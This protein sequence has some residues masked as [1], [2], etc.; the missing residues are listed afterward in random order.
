MWPRRS[1]FKEHHEMPQSTRNGGRRVARILLFSL[2]A[3]ALVA[4]GRAPEKP[5]RQAIETEHEPVVPPTPV[6]VARARA[7][8]SPRRL[9]MSFAVAV[10]FFAGASFSAVAGDR[11]VSLLGEEGDAAQVAAP[12]IEPAVT[13]TTGDATEPAP[14]EPTPT[15]PAPTEPAP[16][17]AE[18]VPAEPVPAEPAPAEPAPAPEADPA[19]ATEDED[20]LASSWGREAQRVRARGGQTPAAPAVETETPSAPEAQTPSEDAA[21]AHVAP[22]SAPAVPSRARVRAQRIAPAP[23]AKPVVTAP[24]PRATPLDPE[25]TAAGVDATVWVN[26]QLPDPTPPSLRLSPA[27]AQNLVS[28]SR[29]AGADWSLVLGVLR[30]ENGRPQAP[31]R[32]ATISETADRLVDLGS[33]RNAWSAALAI[34]GRTSTSDRAVA[35][36]RYYRAIGIRGLV[37]GLRAEQDRLVANLLRDDRVWIYE[38]GRSDLASG[39]VDVRVVALIAYLAESY[40][41]VTVSCLISGHRLYAR[42]GVISAHVYGEAVDIAALGGTPI[43]GHQQPGSVTEH[44][45]RDILLLPAELRPRQVISLIGMGGPS[46]ALSNH[47]DHIHVGF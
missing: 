16:E 4:L 5:A 25:A 32:A 12:E 26:R 6:P 24:A 43:L 1:S 2:V 21:P 44:A 42:P 13:E 20:A 40:G 11:A 23:A 27:Y 22:A 19:P 41:Q 9:V 47:D 14:A 10:L 34:T 39:K 7:I 33:R 28:L 46:F 3:W 29:K 8:R 17:P 15:E 18:P 37:H 30:A 36:A 45:V 38:G 35:L 31:V